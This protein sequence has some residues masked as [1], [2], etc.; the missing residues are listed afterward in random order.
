[1]SETQQKRESLFLLSFR[2]RIEGDAE[3]K[4]AVQF[5]REFSRYDANTHLEI[6]ARM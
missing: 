3:S 2:K 1:M 6:A 4:L 5:A